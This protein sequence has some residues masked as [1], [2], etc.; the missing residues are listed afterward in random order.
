LVEA[1]DTSYRL[2]DVRCRQGIDSYLT[3]LDAE[4]S[5]YSAEQDLIQ[6]QVQRLSN[7]VV[8]YKV[9]GRGAA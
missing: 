6:I 1:A 8:L 4:R 2:S 5:L 3:V 9:L 7:L